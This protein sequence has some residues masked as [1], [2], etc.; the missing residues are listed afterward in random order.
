[1]ASLCRSATWQWSGEDDVSD[2]F[3][4]AKL[5]TGQRIFDLWHGTVLF[6]E[7]AYQLILLI[8]Y[9]CD[10]A[11]EIFRTSI[12]NCLLDGKAN[13]RMMRLS[14]TGTEFSSQA[15]E[16]GFENLRESPFPFQR[17]PSQE[18]TE[19]PMPAYLFDKSDNL[20]EIG[21]LLSTGLASTMNTEDT[22]NWRRWIAPESDPQPW[23]K[24]AT[25]RHSNQVE[26]VSLRLILPDEAPTLHA[27]LKVC[28]P[29]LAVDKAAKKLLAA[30]TDVNSTILTNFSLESRSGTQWSKPFSPC[31][32]MVYFNSAIRRKDWQIVRQQLVIVC[33]ENSAALL[34]MIASV[35]AR[36][37]NWYDGQKLSTGEI[38]EAT[39]RLH[40]L[41]GVQSAGLAISRFSL[42][43]K[44]LPNQTGQNS[45]R[46]IRS[47]AGTANALSTEDLVLL[48]DC[49]IAE[50]DAARPSF[51]VPHLQKECLSYIT[52]G[53]SRTGEDFSRILDLP[54]FSTTGI[55]V[56]KPRHGWPDEVQEFCFFIMDEKVDFDDEK[57]IAGILDTAI[58]EREVWGPT[59]ERARY[60][61]QDKTFA[62]Q[63]I[64]LLQHASSAS[65][66]L[67]GSSMG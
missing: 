43:L 58:S 14:P 2:Y 47:S 53:S 55:L 23:T 42:C 4:Y 40:F 34:A 64:R 54:R 32:V 15:S 6:H 5:T 8:E 37:V 36:D 7:G 18:L 45:Y 24:R 26:F 49:L 50:S 33:S 57:Q 1:M 25:I 3:V 29:G 56:K 59:K 20:F 41:D 21:A 9:I 39:S 22:Y 48:T 46:W 60:T 19:D 16:A 66:A 11:C 28:F 51:P 10:W 62:T 30:L 52:L 31:R 38:V 65:G 61:T 35:N 44:A 13:Q 67:T 12:L 63:W 27:C 17:T